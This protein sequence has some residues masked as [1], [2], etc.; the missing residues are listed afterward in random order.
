MIYKRPLF[1]EIF[2]L[3]IITSFLHYSALV[4]SLYYTVS[5]FD[6]MMH[7]I[8][9]ALIGLIF[10]LI[11]YIYEWKPF[12]KNNK[13][14]VFIVTLGGVLIVGL[15]WELW[16]LFVGFT[17]IT[18]DLPDTLLDIIMDLLGGSM[19][20]LYAKKYLWQ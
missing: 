4:L 2:S 19:A 11:F 18:T 15:A 17:D 14:T 9:G 16:E 6:I 5:W 1:W 13:A 20:F 7:F 3:S 12:Q 8:G 10:I